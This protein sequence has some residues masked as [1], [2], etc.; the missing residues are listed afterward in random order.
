MY[1]VMLVSVMMV[2]SGTSL[3]SSLRSGFSGVQR[4][5][6]DG[7]LSEPLPPMGLV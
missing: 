4:S 5:R 7:S 3:T 2:V 6:E 1:E